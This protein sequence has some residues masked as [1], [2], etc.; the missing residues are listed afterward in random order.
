MSKALSDME[1]DIILKRQGF[2]KEQ[3]KLAKVQLIGRMLHPSS[4]RET[5]RWFQHNKST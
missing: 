3:I 1:F 5:S 2:T 4:E